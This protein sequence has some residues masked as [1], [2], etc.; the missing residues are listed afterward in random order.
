MCICEK[1]CVFVSSTKTMIAKLFDDDYSFKEVVMI[2]IYPTM[3]WVYSSVKK[4]TIIIITRRLVILVK[5]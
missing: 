3:L 1:V 4:G 5:N 2:I